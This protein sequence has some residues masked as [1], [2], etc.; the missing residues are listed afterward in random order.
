MLIKDIKACC[1]NC[2]VVSDTAFASAVECKREL[3]I[4][5]WRFRNGIHTCP[6][7]RNQRLNVV[8]SS[9]TME[10][11]TPAEVADDREMPDLLDE[12]EE[13]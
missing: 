13:I 5:G 3:R 6:Q 8:M 7:C 9:A 4:L 1:D 2:Q 12:Q 11:F 10:Q